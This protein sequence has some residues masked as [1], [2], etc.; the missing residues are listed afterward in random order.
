MS[1]PSQ[2]ISSG[3]GA[4]QFAQDMFS[5]FGFLGAK[6]GIGSWNNPANA[7]NP[8]LDQ[9]SSR[10]EKY[11]NPYI[12]AGQQGLGTLLGQYGNLVNDPTSMMNRIGSGYQASPG[13]QNQVDWATKAA[14]HAAA[15]GGMA[16]SPMEQQEL[17]KQ[18]TGYAN[19]DYYNYLN[20]GLG[21]YQQG[22]QGLGGLAQMG[23]GAGRDYA[24]II[25]DQ[26]KNQAQLAYAGTDAQNKQN[27]GLAS[28]FSSVLGMF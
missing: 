8:Y 18:I 11:F 23:Y 15:A 21:Q 4:N 5:P 20:Q 14:N 27:G 22:L 25:S 17:A 1:N 2:M 6:L 12:Q 3:T 24:S 19:Q 28:I 26:L 9:L 7:A 16:G 13:F 10:T